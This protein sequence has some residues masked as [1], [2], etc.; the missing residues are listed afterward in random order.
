MLDQQKYRKQSPLEI[1]GYGL[2]D[3]LYALGAQMTKVADHQNPNIGKSLTDF[4]VT[5]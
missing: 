3:M 4:K 2:C 1:D 5:V